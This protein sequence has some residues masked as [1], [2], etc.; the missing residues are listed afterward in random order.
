MLVMGC[1]WIRSYL[2]DPASSLMIDDSFIR[3][4]SWCLAMH[5]ARR[6]CCVCTVGTRT[7]LNI[8]E[9]RMFILPTNQHKMIDA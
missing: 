4:S 9:T 6:V 3:S 2:I 7:N 5:A 1:K 8:G